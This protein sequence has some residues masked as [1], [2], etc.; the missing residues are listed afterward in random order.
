M[1]DRVADE[2]A[3]LYEAQFGGKDRGR[4]RISAKLL[5]QMA[6]RRR[7]YEDDIKAIHRALYERGYLLLDLET[8]FC[9]LSQR[10]FASYR[11]V[12]AEQLGLE[13]KEKP[14][15]TKGPRRTLQ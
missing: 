1:H 15:G 11:R 13:E 2:I 5:S 14:K 3:E 6:D 9:V 8:F 7:L 4:F 12:N 10:T